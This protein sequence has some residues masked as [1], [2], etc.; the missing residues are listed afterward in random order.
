V[1]YPA[2][3]ESPFIRDLPL[4]NRRSV[5]QMLRRELDTPS[6]KHVINSVP[7]S[8]GYIRFSHKDSGLQAKALLKKGFSLNLSSASPA[9]Q[10]PP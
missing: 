5:I 7:L 1:A 8:K 4:P 3:A 9:R 6:R 2:G 10:A